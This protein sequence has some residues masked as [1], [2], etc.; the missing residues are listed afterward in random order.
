[1]PSLEK[2][3]FR[4]DKFLN[5]VHGLV[6]SV[7]I[8]ATMIIGCDK[9]SENKNTNL[10]DVAG[11]EDVLDYMKTFDGRGALTDDSNPTSPENALST[12]SYPDD[13]ALDLVLSEPEVTQPVFINFDHRGRLWVVQYN[14][15]PYPKGLKITGLDQHIRAKF[16][17]VPEPPPGGAKGADKI[18]MFTDTDGDG[19]FDQSKDVITGLNIATSVVLGRGKIWVL[20]PPYLLAYPDADKNEIPQAA[21]PLRAEFLARKMT[22]RNQ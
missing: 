16:D 19:V 8:I 15:Y 17:K 12:F 13:L 20:D 3:S 4:V 1:M 14:Q 11:N 18:T 7:M 9:K 5:D 10:E 22:Q 6:L 21:E 2:F